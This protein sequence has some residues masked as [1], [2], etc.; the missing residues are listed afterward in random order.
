MIVSVYFIANSVYIYNDIS[1]MEL[2]KINE[3]KKHRPL[4]SGRV[5][6]NHAKKL[7]CLLSMTG[8]TM[9]F[10]VNTYSFMFSLIYFI[11]FV[12]YSYPK[13]SLKK[14]F[15]LKESILTSGIF[16]ISLVSSYAVKNY[17]SIN[18]FYSTIL[19]SIFAFVVQPAMADTIDIEADLKQ[20]VKN[21][22]IVLNW[23]RR[24][25]LLLIG[26]LII[27]TL[28]PLTYVNF[29]FNMILPI[30]T[31]V[32]CIIILRYL[33]PI[34]NVFEQTM[35]MKAR[36]IVGLYYVLLQ[37]FLIIGSFKFEIFL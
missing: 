10:F 29:G 26:V 11:L 3:I 32:S 9:M 5:S 18:V 7:V 19:I 21:L 17:Y 30:Y 8:L 28:T 20:G 1:D 34:L 27:M 33:V 12:L 37:I 24:M 6:I 22:A 16:I 14:K 36:R 23:K 2:D 4:S 31:V 13:I 15:L 25:Q 35:V